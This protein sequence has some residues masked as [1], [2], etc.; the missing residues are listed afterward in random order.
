MLPASDVR[1]SGGLSLVLSCDAGLPAPQ[2]FQGVTAAFFCKAIDFSLG[3]GLTPRAL[4][5]STSCSS[6]PLDLQGRQSLLPQCHSPA[7]GLDLPIIWQWSG[8]PSPETLFS[9]HCYIW[10]I[11]HQP[12]AGNYIA[13]SRQ[14]GAQIS[15]FQWLDRREQP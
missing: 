4:T 2:A 7:Q 15:Q 5:S 8:R 3:G 11:Y 9:V 14:Y 6:I 10:K 1:C 13:M 12:F